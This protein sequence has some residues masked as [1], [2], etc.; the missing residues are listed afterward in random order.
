MMVCRRLFSLDFNI[1]GVLMAGFEVIVLFPSFLTTGLSTF[2]TESAFGFVITVVFAEVDPV[3]FFGGETGGL[4]TGGLFAGG[5]FLTS[6]AGVI[7]G[8]VFFRKKGS[9]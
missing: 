1:A 2:F 4:V 7:L 8:E 3:L 6:G 9:M 5:L